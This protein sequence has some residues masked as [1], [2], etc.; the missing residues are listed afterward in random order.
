MMA[1]FSSENQGEN[2]F[3]PSKRADEMYQ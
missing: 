2:G 1:T 3:S